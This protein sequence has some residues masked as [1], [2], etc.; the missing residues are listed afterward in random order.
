MWDRGIGIGQQRLTWKMYKIC[1]TELT[2]KEERALAKKWCYC[3]LWL[4]LCAWHGTF[5][6]GGQRRKRECV[7]SHHKDKK[8]DY[9]LGATL[10]F[11]KSK[12]CSKW[13]HEF[14]MLKVVSSW[15]MML[16]LSEG[17]CRLH[18]E[19][20]DQVDPL[21]STFFLKTNNGFEKSKVKK[22]IVNFLLGEK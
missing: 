14:F 10:P 16:V 11:L 4:L 6:R 8:W 9:F 12:Y 19:L 7:C 21:C 15:Q 17:L 18:W 22:T 2:L 20:L 1:V 13:C 3:L 5:F